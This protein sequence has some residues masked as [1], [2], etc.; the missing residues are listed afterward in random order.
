MKKPGE[1]SLRRTV[2]A[3][4]DFPLMRAAVCSVLFGLCLGGRVSWGENPAESPARPRVLY[5]GDS[6]SLGGFGAN[7]DRLL[8]EEGLDV[9]TYVAGAGS[10]YFWLEKAFPIAASLGAWEKTAH[11]ERREELSLA[12]PKV[13]G[14]LRSCRPQ[15]VVVQ[16]GTQLYAPL[17]Q[18]T[19][20]SLDQVRGVV[21]EF[22]RT[23][24]KSR[25]WIY[26]IAPPTAHPKRVE[27]ALRSELEEIL[28]ESVTHYQGRVFASAAVTE[29]SVPYPD[30]SD[31]LHYGAVEARQWAE[32]VGADFRTF[33]EH[34][35]GREPPARAPV[36][37]TAQVKAR[38]GPRP[39][40]P[41]RARIIA[42]IGAAGASDEL[43]AKLI[44]RRKTEI[45]DPASIEGGTAFGVFE[46]EVEKVYQGTYAH[47]RLRVAHLLVLNAQGTASNR[48]E[49][50]KEYFLNLVQMGKY[51]SLSKIQLVCGLE[52]DEK[53]PVYICR[54]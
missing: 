50:G 45:A 32:A 43:Q 35:Q 47:E 34:V 14:L 13:E 6:H 29:W 20:E 28:R 12:V 18:G 25:A 5:L 15:V 51:P 16:A 3:W 53:L 24:S 26:W 48:F 46:Y 10:P 23:I 8:R 41:I 17:G 49:I 33:L 52:E 42:P 44:L 40:G 2:I 39:S 30:A 27:P 31:G 1:F 9:S 54:F 37:L 19:A 21:E 4:S 22:C 38:P 36:D 11:K 7:L